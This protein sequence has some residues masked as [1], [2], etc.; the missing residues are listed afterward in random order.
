[1]KSFAYL[2]TYIRTERIQDSFRRDLMKRITV[3]ATLFSFLTVL[4]LESFLCL[5]CIR[6][7]GENEE[8]AVSKSPEIE[9]SSCCPSQRSCVES[10]CAPTKEPK[11]PVCM[12]YAYVPNSWKRACTCARIPSILASVLAERRQ[13]I[14]PTHSSI[15]EARH[16]LRAEL[17]ADSLRSGSRPQLIHP[18]IATTILRL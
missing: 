2:G 1:M 18:S 13:P 3:A 17:S 7:C 10:E 4:I 14:E 12:I 8:K 6:A 16:S 5:V 15:H 9:C 11:K